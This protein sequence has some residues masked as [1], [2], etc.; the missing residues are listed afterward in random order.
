MNAHRFICG[1]F[2][3]SAPTHLGTADVRAHRC[4]RKRGE[5]TMS[6]AWRGLLFGALTLAVPV[7]EALAQTVTPLRGELFVAGKSA[8]DPSP[9]EPRNSHA[10]VTLSGPAALRMYRAMRAKEEANVCESGRS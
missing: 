7:P 10:Y 5:G 3:F 2:R 9:D 8:I 6:A 1:R 4:F